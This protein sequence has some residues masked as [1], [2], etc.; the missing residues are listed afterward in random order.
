MLLLQI[1]IDGNLVKSQ[2][3]EKPGK[4]FQFDIVID[5]QYPITAPQVHALSNV[6]LWG[7]RICIVFDAIASWRKRSAVRDY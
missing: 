3:L 7:L 2:Y 6:A 4:P 5:A 1:Q